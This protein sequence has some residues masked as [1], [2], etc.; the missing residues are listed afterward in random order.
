MNYLVLTPDGVGSTLLQRA[1]TVYLNAAG[2]EYYNTHELLNGLEIYKSAAVKSSN[3]K[4][5]QTLVEIQKILEKNSANLVSRIADYHV[6]SRLK[7]RNENYD[8]FYKF[9]N[10][11]YDKILYCTRDPYEYALSWSIRDNTRVLNVYSIDQR[12]EHHGINKQDSIDLDF[13]HSKLVQYQNYQYWV[14]DNF[15]D[16]VEVNYNSLNFNIDN[17]IE[18][19][20]SIG[21][22]KMFDKF[23]VSLNDYS[24]ILYK[25]SLIKQKTINQLGVD[26]SAIVGTI[27]LYRYQNELIKQRKIISRI[28]IKMNTLLDKKKRIQN[29]DDTVEV[30]N[31]WAKK[32]NSHQL[33]DTDSILN[34]ISIEN[35][36]YDT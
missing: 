10:Q 20:I 36:Y 16:H 14:N 7:E 8:E 3:I 35:M 29:F 23:N 31:N 15:P 21:N 18:K 19:I 13:F 32:T 11:Y 12:I 33:I 22:F 6:R 1:L 30:Y 2:Q 4:Y 5:E 26:K 34:K 9:C 25:M 27:K 17:E 24:K 28:P